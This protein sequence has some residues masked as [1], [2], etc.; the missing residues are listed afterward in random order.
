MRKI[1]AFSKPYRGAFIRVRN[2][3]IV[4]WKADLVDD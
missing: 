3:K 1:R 4:I 2:K